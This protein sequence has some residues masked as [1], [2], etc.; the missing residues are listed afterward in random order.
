MLWYFFV[1]DEEWIVDMKIGQAFREA[2]KVYPGRSSDGLRFL[3]VEFCMTAACCVP[4]LFLAL[5]GAEWLALLCIPCYVLVMF[6]AR[7]NAAAAMQ[8]AL[9]GGRLFSKRLVDGEGYGKKLAYGLSRA[10]YLILWGAPLIAGAIYARDQISGDTDAL[11]VLRA[12]KA[13]GGGKLMQG[14]L[15]LLYIAIGMIVLFCFGLAWHSGDRHAYVLGDRKLMKGHRWGA[16]GCWICSLVTILPVLVSIGILA[17]RYAPMMS[18]LDELIMGTATLP[19]TKTSI[20]IFAIGAALTV[21]LMPLRSLITAAW[22]RGLK[23]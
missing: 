6:W 16:V 18:A 19:D 12:I 11:T 5:K 13:F 21:P 14:G 10:F 4:L 17:F 22:V 7:V 2:F 15:Y 23:E 1:S 3:T 20:I 9:G 8:D